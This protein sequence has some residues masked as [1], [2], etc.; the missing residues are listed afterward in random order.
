MMH[1]IRY[2]CHVPVHEHPGTARAFN[3][4][5]VLIRYENERPVPGAVA[6]ITRVEFEGASTY[7][8]R[9]KSG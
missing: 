4:M 9:E 2:P 1:T 7:A 5:A 3:C 8:A 6:F